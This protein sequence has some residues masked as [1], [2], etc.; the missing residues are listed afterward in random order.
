MI[1]NALGLIPVLYGKDS[2]RPDVMRS[3]WRNVHGIFVSKHVGPSSYRQVHFHDYV[4]D[5][6]ASDVVN[7]V[8]PG[9]RSIS[10]IAEF[11]FPTEARMR[12]WEKSSGPFADSDDGNVFSRSAAYTV[13]AGGFRD[14]KR[15]VDQPE[16]DETRIRMIAMLVAR[17][18]D[19]AFQSYLVERLAPG[20]AQ[21]D[22]VTD[23][24]ATSLDP[25]EVPD[26]LDGQSADRSLRADE[27]HHATMEIVFQDEAARS[28]FFA[29]EF[30]NLADEFAQQVSTVHAYRAIGAYTLIDDSEVTM[31]GW[32][33]GNSAQLVRETNAANVRALLSKYN[34]AR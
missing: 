32:L 4:P 3:Y 7:R 27:Q 34:R 5:F 10:G 25:Y 2:L 33:G 8:L 15:S 13:S 30:P 29:D 6:W 22:A 17:A 9:R 1:E 14:L 11:V 31:S 20:F 23:V 16:C 24:R 12:A 19:S 21:S 18:A 26:W 28:R